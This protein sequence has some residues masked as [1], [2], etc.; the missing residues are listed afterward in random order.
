MICFDFWPLA[1]TLC[2]DMNVSNDVSIAKIWYSNHLIL[3][4][5]K[6]KV[7]NNTLSFFSFHTYAWK[8]KKNGKMNK[9]F[10]VS[11][12]CSGTGKL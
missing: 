6:T 11:L 2:G 10:F 7:I 5:K 9:I 12:Q 4:L 3:H 1:D 8:K